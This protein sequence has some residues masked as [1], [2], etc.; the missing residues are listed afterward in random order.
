MEGKSDYD[1][2]DVILNLVLFVLSL[3]II[4]NLFN[5]IS[6]T[7]YEVSSTFAADILTTLI[8]IEAVILTI[9]ISLS[10]VVI[11]LTVTSYSSRVTKIYCKDRWYIFITIVYVSII[12]VTLTYLK[13]L[14]ISNQNNNKI[15]VAYVF[16]M[17]YLLI[18]PFYIYRLYK[19]LQP[20]QI[21]ENI[22]KIIILKNIINKNSDFVNNKTKK[23]GILSRLSNYFNKISKKE[24]KKEILSSNSN[25]VLLMIDFLRGSFLKY[26]YESIRE[27][28]EK[29][30]KKLNI[31]IEKADKKE[32][33]E[34]V[35]KIFDGL[36][37]F[38]KFSLIQGDDEII[39]KALDVFKTITN[40]VI[41]KKN[42]DI[43]VSTIITLRSITDFAIKKRNEEAINYIS[44]YLKNFANISIE[45]NLNNTLIEILSIFEDIWKKTRKKRLKVFKD[46]PITSI[47]H[48]CNVGINAIEFQKKE[49]LKIVDSYLKRIGL[50]SIENNYKKDFD[51]IISSYELILDTAIWRDNK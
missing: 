2:K 9:I 31:I 34:A 51:K 36:K 35:E 15:I 42:D 20:S 12:I 6:S 4:L 32:L 39:L 33:S 1:K 21:I 19:I 7:I 50:I 45:K 16:G 11:Q 5:Y 48:I 43:G 18:I 14:D 28:L 23:K 46:L 47:D 37:S 13:T 49:F 24:K 26:D 38:C 3:T 41:N 25:G 30:E 27:G 8:Q 29:M 44:I 17:I 40:C 22:S 10:I